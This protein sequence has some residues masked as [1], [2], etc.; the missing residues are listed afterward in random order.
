MPATSGN[1]VDLLV[2]GRQTFDSIL[3]G[4][5]EAEKYILFQFYI[6]RDDDLW[7]GARCKLHNSA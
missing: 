7:W 2:D 5:K 6:L 1:K 3:A 4:L